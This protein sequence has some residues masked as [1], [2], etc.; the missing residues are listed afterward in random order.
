MNTCI[1]THKGFRDALRHLVQR[2]LTAT[3]IVCVLLAMAACSPKA[4]AMHD[5]ES[6]QS[7]IQ[8]N[9]ENYSTEDWENA[10]QELEEICSRL[11]KE[12]LTREERQ[13][14]FKAVG[15]FTGRAM[16]SAMNSTKDILEN[17]QDDLSSFQEGF[18]N[19]LDEE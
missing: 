12:D 11:D 7:E 3:S 13:K 16:K 17:L 1:T 8:K 18:L 19:S 15:E 10:S 2:A 6:F 14:V 4:K 9:S 5:L